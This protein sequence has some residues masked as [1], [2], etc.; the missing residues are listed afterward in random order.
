MNGWMST[1]SR[2]TFWRQRQRVGDRV[3]R[4]VARSL[5]DSGTGTLEMRGFTALALSAL[6]PAQVGDDTR[7]PAATSG[8]QQLF[9]AFFDRRAAL[10]EVAHALIV[11]ALKPL[12]GALEMMRPPYTIAILWLISNA[13][14]MS[15]V[16]TM[17]VMLSFSCRPLI[18]WLTRAVLIGSRPVVGSS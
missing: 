5:A 2:S 18:R 6:V 12:D 10:D 3:C 9:D 16:T 14:L 1:I 17:L 13:L 15:C 11:R 8:V 7:A 4:Q